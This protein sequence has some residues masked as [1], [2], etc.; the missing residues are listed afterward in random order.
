MLID[1][2]LLPVICTRRSNGT[3]VSIGLSEEAKAQAS[4]FDQCVLT[5][6]HFLGT[7]SGL[8]DFAVLSSI[9]STYMAILRSLDH[10]GHF[11]WL[12]KLRR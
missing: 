6:L 5:H 8:Q 10:K 12:D 9:Y 7:F 11:Q 1:F 4:Y 2:L 3:H